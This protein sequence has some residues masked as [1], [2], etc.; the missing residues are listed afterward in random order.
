MLEIKGDAFFKRAQDFF[1]EDTRL[2]KGRYKM[3]EKLFRSEP[4]T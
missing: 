4:M 2:S 1:N 3:Y